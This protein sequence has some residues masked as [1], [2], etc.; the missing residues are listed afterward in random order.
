ML[1]IA[2]LSR[3]MGGTVGMSA[4]ASMDVCRA[5]DMAMELPSSNADNSALALEWF[6]WFE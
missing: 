5:R 1:L 2:G 3:M 6:E 4:W